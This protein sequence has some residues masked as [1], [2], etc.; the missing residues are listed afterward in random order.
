MKRMRKFSSYYFILLARQ[1]PIIE[2]A[3]SRCLFFASSKAMGNADWS[4]R[5]GTLVTK[6]AFHNPT[7]CKNCKNTDFSCF[8][9]R[10]PFKPF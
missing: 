4:S 3:P 10:F 1:S 9:R 8:F 5:N 2:L 6:T 7:H